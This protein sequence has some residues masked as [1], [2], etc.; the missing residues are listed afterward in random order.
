MKIKIDLS[1]IASKKDLHEAIKQN[2]SLPSDYGA[3]IDALFDILTEGADSYDFLFYNRNFLSG[4]LLS[5][6]NNL[7]FAI[8]EAGEDGSV[9]IAVHYEEDQ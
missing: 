1:T 4:E 5:Y 8:E 6:F 7:V 2:A 9:T 3:N